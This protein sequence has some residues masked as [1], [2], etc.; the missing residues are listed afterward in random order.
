MKAD[1]A[2]QT[3][4]DSIIAALEQGKA[5]PHGW[6]APW[7]NLA[8]FPLNANSKRHYRGSNALYL[9]VVAADRG[10]T[11]PYWATYGKR[12]QDGTARNGWLKL[13]AQVRKGEKGTHVV[14]WKTIE[15]KDKDDPDKIVRRLIPFTYT[16]FNAD[17]VDGWTTPHVEALSPIERDERADKFFAATG[18]DIRHGG[19]RAYYNSLLDRITVPPAE[20]FHS[21]EGYYSTLGHECTHATGHT[22]RCNRDLLNR[23]GSEAYAGEELVA[24]LGSAFLGAHLGIETEPR[25]DHAH[26]IANW[27]TVLRNDPRAIVTAA[28]KAQEAVDWLVSAAGE[29]DKAGTGTSASTSVL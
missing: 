16:V 7:S 29:H 27:L 28:S 26:Y 4:T 8:T 9:S 25:A 19:N 14:A 15:T 5:D 22:L 11:S 6:R 21:T 20:Q 3:I 13:G 17:Q 23:F 2:F 18:L 24:E 12:D 10:Y 1:Q